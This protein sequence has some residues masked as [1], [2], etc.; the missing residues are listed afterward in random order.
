MK[1]NDSRPLA[2]MTTKIDLQ[3]WINQAIIALSNSETPFLEVQVI[4][5]FVLNKSREWIIAHSDEVL[6]EAQLE[7][8]DSCITRL[9]K[10]EP[11]AYITGSQAFF[12]LDFAVSPAVL[13]PRPETELLVEEAIQWLEQNPGRRQAADMCTGSGI[14][15]IS[16]A[17]KI[18]DLL[19]TAMDISEEA[20]AVARKNAFT[21]H[22]EH[23]I[24]W[25]RSDLFSNSEGVFDLILANP[26]YIPTAVLEK[27]EVCKHEPRLALDGGADG[28]QTISQLL[29]QSVE[30]L[31]PGGAL[32][33]EIESSLSAQ[34]LQLSTQLVPD[35]KIDLHFDYANLPRLVKIQQ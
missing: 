25:L 6:S 14:I 18:P 29:E 16:L 4:A 31:R 5:A 2:L 20:L 19:L 9:Q 21:H 17:N 3:S 11:L 13:I 34:I 23:R 7:Q 10:G 27:L 30:H 33:F 32:F 28:L 26:P 35:A 8:L 22:L 1:R 24:N 15:A 12:G